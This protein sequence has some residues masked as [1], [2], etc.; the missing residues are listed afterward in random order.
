MSTQANNPQVSSFRSGYQGSSHRNPP[1]RPYTTAHD[2]DR[3]HA[4]YQRGNDRPAERQYKRSRSRDRLP[5]KS[6]FDRPPE[7]YQK[8]QRSDSPRHQRATAPHS[9][10]RD[11]K[12][13]F[14]FR[15]LIRNR[16]RSALSSDFLDRIVQQTGCF[17]ILFEESSA[18]M[19]D[20]P[21]SILCFKSKQI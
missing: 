10:G 11:E 14:D 13:E 4:D 12:L 18:A 16:A 17:D 2:N 5:R 15:V 8:P 3:D 1:S 21:G 20:L 19:C 6:N 9:S 7:D